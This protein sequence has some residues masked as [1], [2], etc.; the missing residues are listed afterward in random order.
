M[1]DF[2]IDFNN[3]NQKWVVVVLGENI[4]KRKTNNLNTKEFRSI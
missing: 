1:L 3:I 2:V 4:Y